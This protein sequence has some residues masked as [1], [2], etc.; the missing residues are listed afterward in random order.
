[1]DSLVLPIDPQGEDS[2]ISSDASNSKGKA[3]INAY[4]AAKVPPT[5]LP[6]RLPCRLNFVVVQ[7]GLGLATWLLAAPA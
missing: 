2:I 4:L 5:P 1:M 6:S 7:S 3:A